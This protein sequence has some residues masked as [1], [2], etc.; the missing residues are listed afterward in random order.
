VFRTIGWVAIGFGALFLVLAPF[1]KSW[2][3]AVKDTGQPP[4]PEPIAPT[5]DGERQAVNP[6]AMRADR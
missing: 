6:A 2:A 3:H 1:I 4:Q 5:L